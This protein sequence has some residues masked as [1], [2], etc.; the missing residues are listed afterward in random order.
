[1]GINLAPMGLER[2]SPEG[3]QGPPGV[4]LKCPPPLSS[5]YRRPVSAPPT[6]PAATAIARPIASLAITPDTLWVEVIDTDATRDRLWVRP[7]IL[8]R[9]PS[10]PA[11]PCPYTLRDCPDLVLPKAWFRLAIDT[12]A[13]P[14]LSLLTGPPEALVD[15]DAARL[16][17]SD[18]LR[19]LW[20][21]PPPAP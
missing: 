16:A 14:L 1:M 19:H 11:P 4:E 2:A 18:F 9:T 15:G 20:A 7:L 10:D 3:P 17:F 8:L 6:P 21:S 13:L 5:P 12:E